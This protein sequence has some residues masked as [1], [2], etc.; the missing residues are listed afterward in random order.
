MCWVL[1]AVALIDGVASDGRLGNLL[2]WQRLSTGQL[3]KDLCADCVV[4]SGMRLGGIAQLTLFR[5]APS[6]DQSRGRFVRL[7]STAVSVLLSVRQ[8]SFVNLGAR[9]ASGKHLSNI[10]KQGGQ[11]RRLGFSGIM[12]KTLDEQPDPCGNLAPA[13]LQLH[14]CQSALGPATTCQ[15][16]WDSVAASSEALVALLCADWDPHEP[17]GQRLSPKAAS[18]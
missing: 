6:P 16:R 9:I 10:D 3:C 12:T 11:I 1:L 15:G 18:A 4:G 8:C 13:R 2:S 17:S 5:L 7:S 14:L